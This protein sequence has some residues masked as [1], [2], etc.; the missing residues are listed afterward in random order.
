MCKEGST[1]K[2]YGAGILSSVG[3]LEYCMTNKPKFYPL[4]PYEIAQKHLDFP[5]SSMQPHYFVA[6]SFEKAKEQIMEFCEKINKPFCVSYDEKTCSVIVDRKIKTR[7]EN[8]GGAA[9]YW[10]KQFLSFV[11]NIFR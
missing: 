10:G 6:E 2:A 11:L 3:E 4:D 5:I 9:V 7:K 1:Q 8:S